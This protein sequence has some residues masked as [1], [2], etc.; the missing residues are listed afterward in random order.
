MP[1]IDDPSH[2]IGGVK[3][4]DRRSYLTHWD[5]Y[6]GNPDGWADHGRH[7]G[8]GMLHKYWDQ[9][10]GNPERWSDHGYECGCRDAV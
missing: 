1:W 9:C 10:F 4:E 8:R 6:L 2:L 3:K 5:R 7:C